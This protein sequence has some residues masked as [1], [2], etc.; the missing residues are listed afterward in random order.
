MIEIGH[1]YGCLTVLDSGEEYKTS[2]YYRALLS[3]AKELKEKLSDLLI[4]QKEIRKLL[5]EYPYREMYENKIPKDEKYAEIDNRVRAFKNLNREYQRYLELV[6]KLKLKYKCQCQCGKISYYNE[7]TLNKKPRYCFYPVSIANLQFSYSNGAKIANERKRRKYENNDSVKLWY[8]S[9]SGAPWWQEHKI[10]DDS[11]PSDEYCELYNKYKIRQ[12][13][14]QENEYNALIA[15][16]PRKYADNYGAD[17]V[18]K[19]YESLYIK[20]CTNENLESVPRPY[21][22]QMAYDGKRKHWSSIVVRKEYRC[23]CKMCGK[24]QIITCDKFGIFPPTDYGL[25]AYNGYWSNVFCDCHPISSF[26]W[27]VCK[28][29]FDNGIDYEV[30]YSFDDLYGIGGVNLLRYDFAI[31]ENGVIVYLIECQGEQHFMPVDE[32]GG[33]LQYKKQI[34]NDKLK[35]EYAKK[36]NIPLLEISYEDKS[37]DKIKELLRDK[38][39]LL[40]LKRNK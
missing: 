9:P 7:Y 31:K 40:T 11:L 28:L 38:G 4:E 23:E 5:S 25:H 17:Y 6:E 19:Y 26:Q 39:I 30:E 15:S 21:Y 18:G 27:I 13:K 8:K 12:M 33:E 34:E 22:T 32:F 2:E 29:L 1:K 36:H 37:Y 35:R 24:E 20:E 16:L 10:I 14:K 3:E